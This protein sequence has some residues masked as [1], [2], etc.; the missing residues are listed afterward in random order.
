MA[1]ILRSALWLQ[2]LFGALLGLAGCS[3]TGSCVRSAGTHSSP[4]GELPAVPRGSVEGNLRG[5]S[6]LPSA[7]TSSAPSLQL[8]PYRALTDR[9]CQCLAVAASVTARLQELEGGL[10]A[11]DGKRR[12]CLCWRPR[13]GAASTIALERDLLTQASL[14]AANR[15]AGAALEMY[16]RLGEAEGRADLLVEGL[17][18]AREALDKARGM[19]RQQLR[20]P[21]EA[22]VFHRQVLALRAEQVQLRLSI[23]RLNEDLRRLL[24]LPDCP[25]GWRIWNPEEY[26]I[27]GGPLD[28]E[29]AVA[30]GLAR[31]P[32]LV[33]LRLAVSGLNAGSVPAARQMLKAVH[34]LLGLD[35]PGSRRGGE[36]VGVRRKQLEEYLRQ[37]ERAVADEIRQAARDV[38]GRA[39]L[40]ALTRERVLSWRT[41]VQDL[42]G[43][44]Q[45]G[46]AG[47]AEITAAVQ[48]WLKA[49]GDLIQEVMAWNIA[50]TRLR[51]AQGILAL[52]CT[53]APN[54]LSPAESGPSALAPGTP[55]CWPGH[56]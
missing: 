54:C 40:A 23:T 3:Q 34:P 17:A 12:P 56:R 33:L 16:Y 8:P 2:G 19:E 51:Q 21:V 26:R 10:L 5:I 37:R 28:V 11:R 15:S 30:C 20:P 39:Q 35:A 14:E 27:E 44:G 29:A 4:V 36:E 38:R 25:D 42:R 22:A 6:S 24:G 9:Q 53:A 43:R 41:K 47:F 18:A 31:R 52:E 13:L 49:R 46:L 50:R 48:E 45:R 7:E 32:E 1:G 55:C